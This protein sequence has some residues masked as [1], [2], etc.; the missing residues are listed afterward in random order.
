MK[1]TKSLSAIFAALTICGAVYVI[2]TGGKASAGYAVVPMIVFLFFYQLA[3]V[4][5]RQKK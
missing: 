1:I 5:E 4:L 3:R 2:N